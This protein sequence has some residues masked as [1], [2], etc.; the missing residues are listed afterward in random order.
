[1]KWNSKCELVPEEHVFF[2]S[3]HLYIILF[4][5]LLLQL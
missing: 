5:F 2:I 4:A 1:M 3:I